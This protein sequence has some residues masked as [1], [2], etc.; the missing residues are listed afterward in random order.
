[1]EEINQLVVTRQKPFLCTPATTR[2]KMGTE[3]TGTTRQKH[4]R[5]LIRVKIAKDQDHCELL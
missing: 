3:H 4:G 5:M 2:Q 1:M